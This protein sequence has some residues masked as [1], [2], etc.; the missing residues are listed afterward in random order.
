MGATTFG[1]KATGKTAREAFSN[2]IEE[3][4]YEYGHGGYTGT[5]AEK[6]SFKM[7]TVNAQF[8]TQEFWSEVQ[9]IED[10]LDKWGHAGCIKLDGDAYYFFGWAS[11]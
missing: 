5:I 4:Q 6:D 11:C 3:A 2:A 8:K 9:T 7:Y 1:C 10:K